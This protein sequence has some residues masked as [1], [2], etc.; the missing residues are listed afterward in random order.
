MRASEGMED[1]WRNRSRSSGPGGK[2]DAAAG[3]YRLGTVK[4]KKG[5]G[6]RGEMKPLH[7]GTGWQDVQVDEFDEV[8]S[9]KGTLKKS[10]RSM[11]MAGDGEEGGRRTRSGRWSPPPY[12]RSSSFDRDQEEYRDESPPPSPAYTS[13]SQYTARSYSRTHSH[14]FSIDDC[15]SSHRASNDD[16]RDQT[17]LSSGSSALGAQII[18]PTLLA[19]PLSHARPQLF[20]TYSSSAS[21]AAPPASSSSSWVDTEVQ[22]FPD[23]Q[24]SY[25]ATRTRPAGD[26]SSSRVGFSTNTSSISD[27]HSFHHPSSRFLEDSDDDEDEEDSRTPN[28]FSSSHGSSYSRHI[29]PPRS[30]SPSPSPPASPT[31][32]I[33]PRASTYWTPSPSAE[34]GRHEVVIGFGRGSGL[35]PQRDRPGSGLS[36]RG[37]VIGSS[38]NNPFLQSRRGNP[39]FA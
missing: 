4:G 36:G 39:W 7:L 14:S 8:L 11:M 23:F 2:K 21:A 35:P 6:G 19:P 34:G 18:Y 24:S 27:E 15:S 32:P 30:R 5:G 1:R 20:K 29:I 22:P 25:L 31:T 16:L 12:S 28:P 38:S 13:R 26:H 9:R 33:L 3:V 10:V 17:F 37:D